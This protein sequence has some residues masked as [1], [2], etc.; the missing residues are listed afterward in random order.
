MN[1]GCRHSKKV[2]LEV[3]EGE[4]SG[5]S[6][7][8]HHALWELHVEQEGKVVAWCSFEFVSAY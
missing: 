7:Y 5:S 8:L 6:F 3:A 2:G 1:E 4:S